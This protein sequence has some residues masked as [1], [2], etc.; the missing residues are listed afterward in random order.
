VTVK[1]KGV[2]GN[3]ESRREVKS[4]GGGESRRRDDVRRIQ[5]GGLEG[6]VCVLKRWTHGVGRHLGGQGVIK[7]SSKNSK[8]ITRRQK[9]NN[10]EECKKL[11]LKGKV[12]V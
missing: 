1:L 8:N 5:N 12:N 9:Q 10:D 11:R 2:G 4:H 6:G 7:T 3:R